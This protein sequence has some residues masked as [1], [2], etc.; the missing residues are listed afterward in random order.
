MAIATVG[1]AILLHT[2]PT[3][4]FTATSTTLNLSAHTMEK[5][6]PNEAISCDKPSS[7][8]AVDEYIFVDP[9]IEKRALRKFDLV[10]M[11]QIVILVVIS[12][13]DRS[14]VG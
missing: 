8:D 7:N 10:M 12:M 11:P 4:I 6:A 5:D 2:A 1:R 3:I 14:N 9:V 13:L